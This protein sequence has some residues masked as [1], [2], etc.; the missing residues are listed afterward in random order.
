MQYRRI[1]ALKTLNRAKALTGSRIEKAEIENVIRRINRIDDSALN[2]AGV[3][4]LSYK[5]KDR[6]KKMRINNL[7]SLEDDYYEI[8]MRIRNVEDEDDALY[9]MRQLNTRISII[10]DF[11]ESED[12]NSS[13]R[14][15][16]QDSLDRFTRLRSDLSDTMVYKNKNYGIF[17]AYPD[18]QENRY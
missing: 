13:E 14:K 10:S 6:M 3:S 8:N 2:E 4:N 11:I 9:L 12:L 18:I 1:P 7:K 16:W 15:R 5:I 17:V